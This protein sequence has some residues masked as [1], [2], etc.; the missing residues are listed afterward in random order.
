MK[1]LKIFGIVVGSI[2]ILIILAVVLVGGYF[3]FIPGVSNLFGMGSPRDLGV[4]YTQADYQ[5]G[6]AKT[7]SVITDLPSDASPQQS[8]KYSGSHPV[9]ITFTQAEFN[10]LINNHP[11]KYYPFKDCQLKINADG[12]TEFSAVLLTDRL[13]GYAKSTGSSSLSM[14]IIDDYLSKVP[15]N[16]IIYAKG[17]ASVVNGQIVNSDISEFQVGRISISA[18]QLQKN[19]SSST[20]TAQVQMKTI[21]GFS[22][23]NFSM[24]NG[25]IKFEGTLPDSV[26]RSKAP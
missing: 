13:S 6:H 14:K 25:Q 16:P 11:W 7:G 19:K 17:R 12:T 18:D 2:L 8:I 21:P 10:A 5:T 9:N 20:S 26:A 23:K 22:V 15:G 3:G 4:R 1:A 24:V